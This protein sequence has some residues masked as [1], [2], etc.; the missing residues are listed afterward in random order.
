MPNPFNSETGSAAG[1]NRWSKKKQRQARAKAM[2]E[3]RWGK[4]AEVPKTQKTSSTSKTTQPSTLYKQHKPGCGRLNKQILFQP[5][6]YKIFSWKNYY[7]AEEQRMAHKM[8]HDYYA[9]EFQETKNQRMAH[10]KY[11]YCIIECDE[12]YNSHYNKNWK[13]GRVHNKKMSRH[14]SPPFCDSTF[15]VFMCDCDCDKYFNLN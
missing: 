12:N 10:K 14:W 3:K 11:D 4:K 2:N 8:V 15:T 5:C 7:S 1:K 9:R 6:E 13:Y